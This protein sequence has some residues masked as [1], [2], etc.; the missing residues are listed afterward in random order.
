[1]PEDF[2][3]IQIILFFIFLACLAWYSLELYWVL[4]IGRIILDFSARFG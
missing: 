1:M 2:G 4:E 3:Q